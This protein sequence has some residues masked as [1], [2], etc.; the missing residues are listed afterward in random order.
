MALNLGHHLMSAVG[1]LR[2]QP[3]SRRVRA[4]LGEDVVAD[5]IRAC[6]VWEPRRV[7]PS[8]AVPADDLAAE[9][10][11]GDG[12]AAAAHP[13][14]LEAGAPEVLDPSSAF[15]VHTCPGRP[16][17]L[18]TRGAELPDAAFAP[19]DPD[20]AGYVV[21][22]WAAFTEWREEDE[23]VPAHP[24]DPFHRIDC[25]RSSRRV[26]VSLE[27]QV[28]ADATDAVFLY[29]SVLPTRYY[30]PVGDVRTDLLER[31]VRHTWCAYKGQ[32]SYWS[33]TVGGHTAPDIAWAYEEP[34]HDAVPVA[35]RL[36]FFTERLD[37]EVDGVALERPVT[38]WS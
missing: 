1:E 26:V 5:S 27:G 33:A 14:R 7:I 20:L 35:G 11:R 19:D 6:L 4:F 36:A 22:D 29:E 10:V 17:T 18:R 16:L 31:S 25:L 37:L 32:A 28:L 21:L 9:L 34:L 8:Y 23:V 2:I 24:R 12:V 3:S 30:L 13:V 15:S 38:P